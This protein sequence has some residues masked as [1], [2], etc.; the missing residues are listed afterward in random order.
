MAHIL[1]RFLLDNSVPDA[2]IQTIVS[3]NKVMASSVED[4][5]LRNDTSDTINGKL[6]ATGLDAGFQKITGVLPGTHA[7]D[8]VSVSQLQ[9]FQVSLSWRNPVDEQAT[10]PSG[11]EVGNDGWRV[12]INGSG[13]GAFSGHDNEIA[14]WDDVGAS[15]S[16]DAPEANWAVFDKNTD[17]GYTYD[18]TGSQWIQFNGAGQITPG[19]G[20]DKSGNT[21]SVNSSDIS[22]LGLED[23]GSNNL[24]LAAGGF[25]KGFQGGSGSSV[26]FD[27]DSIEGV[28]LENDGT[29]SLRLAAQGD[30]ISGGGGSLLS[31]KSDVTGGANLSRSINVSPNGVSVKVDDST[32]GEDGSQQLEV[33]N[34]SISEH[35]LTVSVSGNG[36]GGGNG[37]PLTVA[38][39]SIGGANIARSVNVTANGVAV[40]VDDDTIGEGTFNRLQV[41]S[42]GIHFDNLDLSA[43]PALEDDGS[44]RTRVKVKS[45]GAITRDADGLSVNASELGALGVD[46]RVSDFITIDSTDI[47]NGYFLITK[48]PVRSTE[49]TLIIIGGG[50]QKYSTDFTVDAG[51]KR[52]NMLSSLLNIIQNG[53]DAHVIYSTEE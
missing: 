8:V 50:A 44:G 16:F 49:V 39:D 53:D 45:G 24:R 10:S 46:R 4:K 38:S 15:W 27:A 21:L 29:E 26:T 7:N 19:D 3:P 36:I 40:K 52:V 28:G 42:A 41:K 35:K 34:N 43:N 1:G 17:N 9:G 48:T 11:G 31:V 47:S 14:T 32:I 23:D 18:D 5:F 37:V 30:G 51:N 2:K 20:I 12:L 33:K 13:S 6:F 25:G 22:G